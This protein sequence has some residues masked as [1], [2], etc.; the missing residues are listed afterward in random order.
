MNYIKKVKEF[1]NTFKQ[2]VLDKPSIPQNRF[3]FRLSL[4]D[5][6]LKELKLACAN[7]DLV[8]VADAFADIM[9]VLCG[10][11]LEFGM[12]DKFLDIF[13]EV[14]RSNMSKACTTEKEMLDTMEFYISKGIQTH[15]KKDESGLY[16]VYRSSDNKVLKNI[17]YSPA[18]LKQFLK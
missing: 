12:Q 8:E 1:H 10:A 4:L 7:N 2:P 5:E 11:I 13:N 6:E 17:N 16:I 15:A 9:Y 3:E 18:D 14:H